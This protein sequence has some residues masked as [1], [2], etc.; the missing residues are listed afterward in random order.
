MLILK[1]GFHVIQR[2]TLTKN[3]ILDLPDLL[4]D[5]AHLAKVVYGYI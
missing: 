4:S 5:M 1:N 3:E 2:E